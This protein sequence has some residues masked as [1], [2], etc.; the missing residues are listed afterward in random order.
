MPSLPLHSID[1]Y[2]MDT[3]AGRPVVLLH[4]L[5]SCSDDWLFQTP[6][7]APHFRVIAPDLRGHGHSTQLDGPVDVA[8]L[9]A[10]VA[11]LMDGLGIEHAH[12]V[13]LSLGGMVAQQLAID[14]A[15][16]VDRLVLTNTFAHLWPTNLPETYTLL[17]RAC[18]SL[19]L[20]LHL[21]AR[22]VAADLFPRPDQ[23]EFRQAVIERIGG[24]DVRSYRSFVPA[25]RPFDARFQLDRIKAGTL[26]VT[27]DH[28]NVVPRGCQMQLVRGIPGARWELIK[29]SGHA[30]P[31]DQPEAFNRVVLE[32]L[33]E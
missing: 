3:G 23:S 18:V 32:F 25:I 29:D 15:A 12:I 8:M 9:A 2:Y 33:G 11:G 22:V 13:G 27:G 20:P 1:L 5:G 7:F 31:I 28:D 10:D 21:T 19:L 16:K 30:T 17:R 26:V 24:N 4:G 14:S 6:V